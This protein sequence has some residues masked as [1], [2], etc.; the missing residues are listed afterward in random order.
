MK[1]IKPKY[2][3]LADKI[4]AAILAG[5]FLPG[6]LIPS[7]N[8]LRETYQLSRYTVRQAI[9]TLVGEGY[10]RKEQGSGTYVS[11]ARAAPGEKK[12]KTIGVVM[13]YLSDYIFPAIIRG[14]EQGLS[15]QGYSL[16]LETTNNDH[17][18][19][20]E[21]LKRLMN[22][23]VD[24]LIIEPTKSNQYNPNLDYYVAIKEQGV[25]LLVINAFYEELDVQSICVNDTKSGYLATKYWIE[26]G[27][28]NILLL[29]KIDDLQGKYRMKG[30]IKA[31]EEAHQTLAEDEIVTYTTET[32]QAVLD[33]ILGRVQ[34]KTRPITGIVVYN[35]EVAYELIDKLSQAGIAVPENIS[36]V[37][38]DDSALATG[39]RTALTTLT[40]PKEAMGKL[41]AQYIMAAIAGKDTPNYYF[42]P[43]LIIRDSVLKRTR[44]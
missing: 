22:Q 2:R 30:F 36:L 27:H 38:N 24:G 1:K 21:C 16:L 29:T 41:A 26:N 8:A 42:E 32:K 28:E 33:T 44:S 37:G 10:L 23:N 6:E 40:H 7:E 5:E 39:G 35:D 17:G 15:S 13:T 12:T 11:Q 31:V 18:K 34:K 43:K 3:Q 14:L 25:P 9:D 19:E 4:K 20:R